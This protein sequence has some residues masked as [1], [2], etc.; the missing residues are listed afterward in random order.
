MEAEFFKTDENKVEK[1]LDSEFSSKADGKA[2]AEAKL[3][4]D[5]LS[6][7]AEALKSATK[8][9]RI[10]A[11]KTHFWFNQYLEILFFKEKN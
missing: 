10:I 2:E 1:E 11:K 5:K 6:Y 7:K 9:Q 8:K 3:A 4:V